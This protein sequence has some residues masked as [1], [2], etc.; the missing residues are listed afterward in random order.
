MENVVN[1]KGNQEHL[2]TVMVSI[3][4]VDTESGE[5]V[6]ISGLGNGQDSGDK[7]VMKANT[8]AIKYAYLMIRR[9]IDELMSLEREF[10]SRVHF[11]SIHP[12]RK[13]SIPQ[14]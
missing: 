13:A 11:H 5:S 7:A 3:K 4:L 6:I 2:A 12:V 14:R 1:A 9:R 10:L 8:A